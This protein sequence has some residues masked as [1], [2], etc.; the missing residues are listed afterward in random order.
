MRPHA[1]M[2]RDLIGQVDLDAA[3]VGVVVDG[4]VADF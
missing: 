1:S 3:G 4:V 2:D